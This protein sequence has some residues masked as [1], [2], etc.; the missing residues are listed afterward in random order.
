MLNALVRN[1]WAL[2]LRGVAALLFGLLTFFL[3][4]ITL[5]DGAAALGSLLVLK[6][7]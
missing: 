4:G 3:P 5:E 1:W 7:V 2:A 6:S